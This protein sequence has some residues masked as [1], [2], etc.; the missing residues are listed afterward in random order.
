[1]ASET[2]INLP[3]TCQFFETRKFIN[4]K[5]LEHSEKCAKRNEGVGRDIL[6][7]KNKLTKIKV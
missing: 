2:F 5:G 3:C 6:D 4:E 7:K 1:M